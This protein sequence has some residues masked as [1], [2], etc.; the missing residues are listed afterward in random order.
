[1]AKRSDAGRRRMRSI[2]PAASELSREPLGSLGPRRDQVCLEKKERA[3]PSAI[4]HQVPGTSKPLKQIGTAMRRRSLLGPRSEMMMSP[5]KKVQLT[6]IIQTC[7]SPPCL[8][9]STETPVWSRDLEG[10]T[11]CAL[12]LARE[13]GARRQ[14][15]S[16][17]P[18]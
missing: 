17:S 8:A 2:G 6:A 4:D 14:E 3:T 16:S 5:G 13:S 15:R 9:D 10:L 1:M 11:R 18:H 12:D 7:P